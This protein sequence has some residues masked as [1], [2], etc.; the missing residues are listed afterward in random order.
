[1]R[2]KPSI[3][4]VAG[5]MRSDARLPSAVT[6][7]IGGVEFMT[8]VRAARFVS[9]AEAT[10]ARVYRRVSPSMP[11]SERSLYRAMNCLVSAAGFVESANWLVTTP[12][13]DRTVTRRAPWRDEVI[14]KAGANVVRLAAGIA[15]AST[16]AAVRIRKERRM[17][18]PVKED[19]RAAA[20]ERDPG[21]VRSVRYA[22]VRSLE[23]FHDQ[24]DDMTPGP[25]WTRWTRL[26]VSHDALKK[27]ADHLRPGPPPP[28]M[29]A[30]HMG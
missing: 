13:V 17:V 3:A 23:C 22:I 27:G 5:S 21:E 20:E 9:I 25:N 30:R 7:L 28:A 10:L 11:K 26:T 1:M 2:G 19:T 15:R 16:E 29:R 12:S 18:V 14:S 4:S 8:R 6:L 24:L